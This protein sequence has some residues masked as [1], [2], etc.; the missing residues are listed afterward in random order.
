MYHYV[1]SR[2]LLTFLLQADLKFSLAGNVR[3]GSFD[4]LLERLTGSFLLLIPALV[5]MTVSGFITLTSLGR[6]FASESDV[7]WQLPV[8]LQALQH[9]QGADATSGGPLSRGT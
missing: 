8:D 6:S 2:S 3:A 7:R 4:R 1:P 5:I 9:S